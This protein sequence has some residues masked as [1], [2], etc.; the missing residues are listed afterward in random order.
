MLFS[1]LA[2]AIA[3]SAICISQKLPDEI[4]RLLIKLFGLFNLFLSLVASPWFTKLL[5][6][7]VILGNSRLTRY[8][9]GAWL[10]R[11]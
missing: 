2:L 1:L 7:A 8:Q 11:T 6:V 5:I 4:T 10:T 3:I 9:A